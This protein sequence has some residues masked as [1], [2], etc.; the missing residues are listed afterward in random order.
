MCSPLTIFSQTLVGDTAYIFTI[1]K[2]QREDTLKKIYFADLDVLI[3][4]GSATE[5]PKIN[6][7][8]SAKNKRKRRSL[9][10]KG[11]YLPFVNKLPSTSYNAKHFLKPKLLEKIEEFDSTNRN[12]V[13]ATVNMENSF[14]KS[15]FVKIFKVYIDGYID[16]LDAN[17]LKN[18]YHG[19]DNDFLTSE[20]NIRNLQMD[21]KSDVSQNLRTKLKINPSFLKGD[22]VPFFIELNGKVLQSYNVRP[23]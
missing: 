18:I 7:I 13:G 6:R 20:F 9:I 11:E 22:K 17:S 15:N 23:L 8:L 10:K 2:A 19:R 16:I 14:S 5:N 4:F 12:A 3:M 1:Y 21:S